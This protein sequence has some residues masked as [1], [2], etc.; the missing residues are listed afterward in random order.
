[1]EVCNATYG[2]TGWLGVAQIWTSGSHIVQDTGK[3][4]DTYFNTAKYNKPE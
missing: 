3:L 4:N 2:N 1:M